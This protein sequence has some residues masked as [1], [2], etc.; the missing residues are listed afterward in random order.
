MRNLGSLVVAI[1][2]VVGVLVLANT[3]LR[4]LFALTDFVSGVVRFAV[5]VAV[6]VIAGS[7]ALAAI[8]RGQAIA[9]VM[10]GSLAFLCA[11]GALNGWGLLRTAVLALILLAIEAVVFRTA[12]RTV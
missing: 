4:G 3:L 12:G 10:A 5:L 1:L 9:G 8:K 6:A 7:G 2:A 11:W